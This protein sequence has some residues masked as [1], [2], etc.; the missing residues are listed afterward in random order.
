[1]PPR[2]LKAAYRTILDDPFPPELE[3]SFVAG[4]ERQTLR[5]EKVVWTIGDEIRGLR[6]GENPDQ[7]AAMY[8]LVNG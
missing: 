7:P 1:M 4:A 5:Y 2:D 3:I 8:K 6:Y